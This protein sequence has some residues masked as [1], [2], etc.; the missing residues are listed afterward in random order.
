MIQKLTKIAIFL[1]AIYSQA[2]LALNNQDS[3]LVTTLSMGPSWEKA[4]QAQTLDLA[5]GIEKTYTANKPSNTLID[6]ELFL[7]VQKS[8]PESLQGQIGL[9]LAATSAA[10]LSGDIWDDADPQFNNYIYQYK[11]QHT[12]IALKG[13]L[14]ADWGWGILPWISGSA[15]VGFN[16]SYG[17]TNTP[18]I[19]EAIAAPNFESY[20]MTAFTYTLGIGIQKPLTKN[21]QI[22]AGYEFANW[23]KS[24]LGTASDETTGQTLSLSNL[25]THS[26]LLNV[27][28]LA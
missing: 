11:I 26:F 28:Y 27:S 1:V 2:T 24:K 6:S 19:Y 17:F 16:H 10:S 9:A 21:W 20:T 22:G 18:T 12:H 15:G 14:L 3:S 8:L 13:K 25:Y 4:G 7:G 5:P 23:G